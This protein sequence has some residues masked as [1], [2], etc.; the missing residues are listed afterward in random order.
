MREGCSCWDPMPAPAQVPT[1]MQ[2]KGLCIG[3]AVP[4]QWKV[5]AV[6]PS[7]YLS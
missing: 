7:S 2:G 6:T 4:G 1:R 3:F 5:L